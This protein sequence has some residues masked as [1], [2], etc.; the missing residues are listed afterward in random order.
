M[1]AF[2]HKQNNQRDKKSHEK[3]HWNDDQFYFIKKH[4]CKVNRNTVGLESLYAGMFWSQIELRVCHIIR[5]LI[6]L[7]KGLFTQKRK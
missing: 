3:Q 1:G 4:S 6:T 7:L 5:H 2:E